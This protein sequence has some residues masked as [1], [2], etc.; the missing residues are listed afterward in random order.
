MVHTEAG[1]SVDQSI[2]IHHLYQEILIYNLRHNNFPSNDHY[3]D[4]THANHHDPRRPSWNLPYEDLSDEEKFNNTF[5]LEEDFEVEAY[6]E[7]MTYGRGPRRVANPNSNKG[8]GLPFPNPDRIKGDLSS[9]EYK[10]KIEI[11]FFSENLDIES[12]LNW[13][14][15]VEKFFDM[16]YISEEKHVKFVTYELKEGAT[17]W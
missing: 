9:N 15:E 17:T 4:N 8:G 12:F 16:A 11:P 13:V 10:M 6:D 7:R 5:Y 2:F 1:I 14:Y 3:H